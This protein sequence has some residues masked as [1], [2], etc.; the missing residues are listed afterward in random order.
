MGKRLFP[1]DTLEQAVNTQEAWARIDEGLAF[2]NLS[3][4][5][6]ATDIKGIRSVEHTLASLESQLTE[7]R[8]QREALYLAAWDKVKRVRASI[9][10][11]YGDD[12]TQYEMI[13]GTRL[14]DRK[15]VRKSPLPVEQPA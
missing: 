13:G 10:G 1:S 15:T 2:G 14:S 11:M 12:S 4:A 8:N 9:K 6:L 5:A 3:V 7:M